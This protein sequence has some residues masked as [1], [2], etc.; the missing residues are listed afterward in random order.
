MTNKAIE[1]LKLAQ[2][3]LGADRFGCEPEFDRPLWDKYQTAIESLAAPSVANSAAAGERE[4]FEAYYRARNFIPEY[5]SFS[6]LHESLVGEAWESWQAAIAALPKSVVA[7]TNKVGVWRGSIAQIVVD[8]PL[9]TGKESFQHGFVSAKEQIMG[10][11]REAG[12]LAASGPDAKLVEALQQVMRPYGVYDVAVSNAG[13]LQDDF[14]AVGKQIRA[15][16]AAH[17]GQGAKT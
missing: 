5:V 3:Q 15:A 9:P 7:M 16:L 12:L 6:S 8:T 17:A 10:R 11:L 2:N 4:K 13:G 14:M 1:A